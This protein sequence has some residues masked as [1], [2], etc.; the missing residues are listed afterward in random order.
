[1]DA[2]VRMLDKSETPTTVSVAAWLGARAFKRW[3]E[4]TRFI[5]DTYPGVFQP[6]WLY[7]GKN[8]GWSLRFK[9]SKPLCTFVP[10]R[11][12][13]KVLAVFGAA[14]REKVE[15]ILPTINSHVRG[16]Y[17]SATTYHD[18]KWVLVEV[19]STAVMRDV[20]RLLLLKRKPP[21]RPR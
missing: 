15:E 12:R 13:F 4:L 20:E 17:E 16:D 9:K 7:A 1:M 2:P 3:E 18:G 5:H 10:E 14:E 6:E 11:G 8:H 19:D 21:R